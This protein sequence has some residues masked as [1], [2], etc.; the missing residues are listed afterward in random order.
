MKKGIFMTGT[1]TGV[2][3]TFLSAGLISAL[4][5]KGFSV[6]PM[7]P[8]ETGCKILKGELVPEDA[9]KLV[10]AA[11]VSEP[12]DLVNP[13]RFKHPLAPS[14]AAELEGAKTGK[15]KIIAAYNKLSAGYDIMIVEGAGGIMVPIY[16][17]YLY[18]DL[19]RDLA[20]PVVIISRPGLGTINHTLLTIEAARNRGIDITGVIINYT[21]RHGKDISMK[22]NPRVIE[23][24][25]GTPVLGVVPYMKNFRIKI[26]KD[27]AAGILSRL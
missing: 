19:I 13:Y 9:L 10:K 2:G 4:K 12:L 11:G 27:L 6:C 3:K 20:L 8:V 18:L 5:E 24:L 1:D 23:K 21:A 26:F 22:T 16:N 17:K 15:R 14:V 7:K 25:T